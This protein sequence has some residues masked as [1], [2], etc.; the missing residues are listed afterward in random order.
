[1]RGYYDR[2]LNR[3]YQTTVNRPAPVFARPKGFFSF[4]RLYS[5][6]DSA[7]LEQPQ[8]RLP[9][10]CVFALNPSSMALDTTLAG[11]KWARTC[12]VGR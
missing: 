6:H 1:M 9:T 3:G 7:L 5:A 12:G 11:F 8:E 2:P 4:T 10:P